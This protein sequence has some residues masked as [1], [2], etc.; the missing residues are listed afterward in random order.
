M[1]RT[2]DETRRLFD[3]WAKSYDSDLLEG[4]GP[5][6]GYAQSVGA[7][8]A[9]LPIERNAQVLDIG[10]G[11]GAIAKRLADRG[12]QITGIDISEKMLELCGK[13]NPDFELHI[14]T[15]DNIPL[16]AGKFDCVVSGFAFHETLL[17]KRSDA[18]A[19]MARVLKPG[20]YLC[21]LDIMFVSET[22]MHEARQLIAEKWDDDEDYAMVGELDTLLRRSGFTMLRWCQ[23]APFHWMVTARKI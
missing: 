23:T 15:F 7:I 10:I 16:P 3:E 9:M 19:E 12:A 4:S 8:D 2:E 17:P 21:L 22:A 5:L 18:C 1:P 13:K 6:L 14:G 20:G 11:S